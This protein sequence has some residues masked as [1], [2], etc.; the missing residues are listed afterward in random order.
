MSDNGI[1]ILLSIQKSVNY[2]IMCVY[3]TIYY[4]N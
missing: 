2:D 4:D 3:E 1:I